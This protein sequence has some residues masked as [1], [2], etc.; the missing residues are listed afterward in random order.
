MTRTAF[1]IYLRQLPMISVGPSNKITV[2]YYAAQIKLSYT[3]V[4]SQ[5]NWAGR[6]LY[7]I[8]SREPALR[9]ASSR[10]AQA[11]H[12]PQAGSSSL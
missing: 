5:L 10:N 11:S 1:H 2:L 12:V 6:L 9:N 3:S 4:D 8:G 7:E